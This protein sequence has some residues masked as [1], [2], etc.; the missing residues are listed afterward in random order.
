[1]SKHYL[2]FVHGIGERQPDK[3]SQAAHKQAEQAQNKNYT[4]LWDN[5]AFA[6]AQETRGAF[7]EAFAPIYT[8]W[9]T[10]QIH[11]AEA[12]VYNEAFPNLVDQHLSLIR[13]L[14]N[15]A[16]FFVG[17]VV[18]YVSQD[19]NVIRR[20]VWQQIWQQLKEPLIHENATYSIV[21][22]SL[23]TVIMFDYLFKLLKDDELFVTELNP[24]MEISAEDRRLLREQFCHFFTFGSPIGLFMLRQGSLWDNNDP[25]RAA[26]NPIRGNGRVWLNFYD[27]RDLIAYPLQKIFNLN[28]Q[29]H[30]CVL[31]DKPV[32]AGFTPLGAHNNYWKNRELAGAIVKTLA[33][34]VRSSVESGANKILTPV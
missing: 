5:L 13:P 6:Y 28:P 25:F 16:T 3:R 32:R 33:R 9:H 10:K 11:L 8:D 29:N 14:R 27:R 18:A 21:S 4:T 15:F 19:V 34:T 22:H 23:G 17:D 30:G 24:D 1:M 12:T 2:I 26:H 20:T 31:E 7:H